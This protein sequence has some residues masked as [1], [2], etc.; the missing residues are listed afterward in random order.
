MINTIK[1][2]NNYYEA[3]KK[4]KRIITVLSN[5]DALIEPLWKEEIRVKK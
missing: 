3:T 5:Y 2:D 1:D 4:K